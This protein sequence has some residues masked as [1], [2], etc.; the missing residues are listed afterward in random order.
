MSKEPKDFSVLLFALLSLLIVLFGLFV[1]NCHRYE[2]S[3]DTETQLNKRAGL[4]IS[5]RKVTAE[6]SDGRE[7]SLS[8]DEVSE[9]DRINSYISEIVATRYP[10][11][12]A[13]LIR[14]IVYHESRYDPD[15]VN[16][17]TGVVGLM[18]IN[19][20][21]HTA[22]AERLGVDLADP[23]GNILVGCDLLNESAS[24]YSIEYAI[25]LYAGGY[26]YA[27]SYVGSVSPYRRAVYNIK[28]QMLTGE[29]VVGG[30]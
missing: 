9:A 5:N 16:S 19:P 14:A 6:N 2:Q 28:E 4:H 15:S 18:Q 12:D 26:S 21:W 8:L 25:D 23:Y 17:R 30:D 27:N 20:K 11:L 3:L 22:R 24:A 29:I 7:R 10:S 1:V 13:D